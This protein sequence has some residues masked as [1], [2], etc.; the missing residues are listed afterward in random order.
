MKLFAA[1]LTLTLASPALAEPLAGFDRF[2]VQPAHR[3]APVAAGIWAPAARETYIGEVGGN[4]VFQPERAWIGAALP[5]EKLPLV[6]ISHGSGSSMKGVAWLGAGLAQ[7][8]ALVVLLNHPGTTSGDSS[9]RRTVKLSER[10]ADLSAALDHV[11]A[12]PYFAARI[13]ESRISALG[14]SL[15][16]AAVLGL[17][18]QRLD[19]A[20]YAAY[21]AAEGDEAPDCLF[22]AKG[23]VDFDHLPPEFSADMSDARF[24]SII[25]V[26]PAFT[27]AATRESAQAFTTPLLLLSLGE[28]WRTVDLSAEGSGLAVLAPGAKHVMIP[29]AWHFSFLPLC[30]ENAAQLLIEEGEDPICDDPEGSDRSKVHAAAIGEISAFLGLDG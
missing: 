10:A 23:G 13:D 16:G 7:R 28:A 17:G 9:P 26:D 14:F 6:I 21:C 20:A 12:D 2:D 24:T 19:P 22:L 18:G 3:A 1:A 15:G 5:D 25:A 30:T 8:G 4:A 29:K 11:L 27:Y